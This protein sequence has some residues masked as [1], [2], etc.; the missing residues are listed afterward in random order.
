MQNLVGI[1]EVQPALWGQ[2][3][4]RWLEGVQPSLPSQVLQVAGAVGITC[5]DQRALCQVGHRIQGLGVQKPGADHGGQLLAK[6][7]LGSRH[8]G[9][10]RGVAQG[11][12]DIGRGQVHGCVGRVDADVD[13]GVRLLESLQARNQPQRSKRRPGRDGHALPAQAL[14]DLPHC[15][16]H[17]LQRG[18]G[19]AKQHGTCCRQLHRARVPQKQGGA[20][21]LFKSLYLTTDSALG[22]RQLL[23]RSTKVLQTCDDQKR[24]Q[25]PC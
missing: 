18:Q 20:H 13:V 10:G 5:L 1:V 3:G 23:S 6:Q 2:F 9:L 16:V 15:V 25:I 4:A 22:Q 19:G 17:A 24:P 8:H 11:Q 21:L 12:V 7:V 14:A